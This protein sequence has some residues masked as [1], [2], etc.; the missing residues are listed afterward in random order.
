MNYDEMTPESLAH[1][2]HVRSGYKINFQDCKSRIENCCM[3]YANGDFQI[4][5][6]NNI[7][8][9]V[10]TLA[11]S[12]EITFS[13]KQMHRELQIANNKIKSLQSVKTGLK[14]ILI[15]SIILN[16]ISFFI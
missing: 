13:W 10:L 4:N 12:K 1:D 14:Y 5:G 7:P 6:K 16:V 9:D 11:Q 3:K 8:A 15:G 2:I